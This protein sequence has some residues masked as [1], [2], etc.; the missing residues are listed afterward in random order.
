MAL[1]AGE[2]GERRV[3]DQSDAVDR[4]ASRSEHQRR[5]GA[6]E[7]VRREGR[8]QALEE[9]RLA[10]D[11]VVEQDD[12][13]AVA[14]VSPAVARLGEAAALVERN[15]P[16]LRMGLADP[17][18][19]AVARAVVHQDDLVENGLR[20]EVAQ[21]AR[22]ELVAVARDDHHVDRWRHRGSS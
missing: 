20:D 3:R 14:R 2:A 9:V 6:Q 8:G 1:Q 12:D 15:D 7:R 10:I 18:R 16:D 13:L 5:R 4:P 19:C 17:S 11:V 22:G 21:A